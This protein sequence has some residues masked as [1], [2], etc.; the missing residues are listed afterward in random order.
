MGEVIEIGDMVKFS[1]EYEGKWQNKIVK[2]TDVKQSR[3]FTSGVGVQIE[4]I[5]SYFDSGWFSI[6][7]K[8]MP[9]KFS[10]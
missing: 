5:K 8:F 4:G 2:V 7:E 3:Q 6:E 1:D 9:I 10:L